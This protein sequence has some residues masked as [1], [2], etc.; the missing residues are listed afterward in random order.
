[1]KHASCSRRSTIIASPW[2]KLTGIALI[3]LVCISFPLWG[4]RAE[5][6]PPGDRISPAGPALSPARLA[7]TKQITPGDCPLDVVVVM[8]RSDSM[9]YDTICFNCFER[10]Q[11]DQ[12]S[13]PDYVNYPDNGVRHT[14][15][16]AT[17]T[18]NLCGDT[19]DPTEYDG[20]HYQILEAELYSQN[21]STWE[22]A[23]RGP[24][25]GYWAINRLWTDT[26]KPP[27]N[28]DTSWDAPGAVSHHP[29]VTFTDNMPSSPLLGRFYTLADAQ[30][31]IA[32]R[33][34]YD[35]ALPASW[36]GNM[37]HIW[38]R[39]RQSDLYGWSKELDG[40]TNPDVIYWEVNDEAI[41][42]ADDTQGNGV[43][44]GWTWIKLGSVSSLAKGDAP[45]TWHTLK[46]YAGR[47]GYT[48]DRLI[49]T[50][51]SG[52]L[53]TN[54]TSNPSN[55]CEQGTPCN[56]GHYNWTTAGSAQ[57]QA[58]DPCN[59]IYGLNITDPRTVA[60]GGQCL[61]YYALPGPTDNLSNELFGDREPIRESKE[62]IKDFISR[63]DPEFDQVGFVYYNHTASK[64]SELTCRRCYGADC[65][66]GAAAWGWPGGPTPYTYTVVLNSV[67][68]QWEGGGTCTACGMRAGLEMLGYN[69][70]NRGGV[71]NLCDGS[72]DSACARGA[73]ALPVMILLTDGAPNVSPGGGV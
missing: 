48:I 35:F 28:I 70:D 59:P 37:A 67:E 66:V 25:Q 46:L 34:E 68:D 43:G 49:V 52:S 20:D 3:G 22:R 33:L 54:V 19:L 47:P 26:W 60:E 17:L 15:F 50:D 45:Y 62:A 24:G 10:N 29:F 71:D 40:T 30:N 42:K 63:L 2:S 32:P 51:D 21:S 5:A 8:D 39:G 56:G 23:F 41:H 31:G 7:P 58:C 16:S 6:A 73:A 11:P 53:P 18:S 64:G 12:V 72:A 69:V 14:V 57:R 61:G 55:A 1:M 13:N 9:N 4:G 44:T 65:Y 36:N 38:L 27:P